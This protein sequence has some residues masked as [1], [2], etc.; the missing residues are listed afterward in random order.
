MDT[1]QADA[2]RKSL[3]KQGETIA[4]DYLKNLGFSIIERNV[5]I[6]HKELDIIARDG[7][8]LVIIEV[9]TRQEGSMLSGA[10]ALTK[11]KIG[12]VTRAGYEYAATNYGECRVRFDS[13]V[14]EQRVDGS[15]SI[16]HEKNAFYAPLKRIY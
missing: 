11:Q 7:E 13:V 15:F 8:W 1:K 16:T 9:K 14:C 3:G 6:H 10:W 4:C 12:N 2:H 5:H